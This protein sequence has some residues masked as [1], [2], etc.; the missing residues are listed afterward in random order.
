MK[1]GIHLS[2]YTKKWSEDVFQYVPVSK[3]LGYDGVE[4]PLM[5]PSSFNTAKAKQLLKENELA[6]TCGTGLNPGRDISSLEIDCRNKGIE[7][8][9]QCINICHEL[10][11]DCLGGV[12]YAPWGQCLSREIAQ[13]NI[14]NSRENRHKLGEYAKEKGVVLALEMI[15]RYESYF[16]NTVEDGNGYLKLINHSNVKLHFDTFHANIEEKNMKQALIK[17]GNNIYHVHVCENDRGIPG[18]GQVDWK[19]VKEGLSSISYNRWITLENFVTPNCEVGNDTFIWRNIEADGMT[20]AIEGIK[21]M[22]EL[23]ED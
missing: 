8:L 14:R 17:G 18:N 2:T 19:S 16:L 20:V 6:C 3:N 9:K 15:N 7:H 1:Y 22:K 12:L 23:L 5:D 13:K 10:E 4:F 11:S 21:F